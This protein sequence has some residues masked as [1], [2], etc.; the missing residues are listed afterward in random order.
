VF[1]LDEDRRGLDDSGAATVEAVAFSALTVLASR[2]GAADTFEGLLASV[3]LCLLSLVLVSRAAAE[4]L[5]SASDG[6][7]EIAASFPFA[8]SI[9]WRN[10]LW[11]LTAIS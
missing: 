9:W 11:K 4:S 1:A 3:V 10:V 2:W 8:L 6:F 7:A 5:V